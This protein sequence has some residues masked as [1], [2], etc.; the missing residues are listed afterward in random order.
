M[1]ISRSTIEMIRR[2]KTKKD[3]TLRKLRKPPVWLFPHGAERLYIAYL[4]Q[5]TFAMRESITTILM[6]KIKRMLAEATQD[7]PDPEE[8]RYDSLRLDDFIDDL[9][10]T[11]REVE[12]SLIP[13]EQLA[14]EHAR[15]ISLDVAK[16]NS[17]QLLKT[18]KSVLGIDIF[19]NQ[20]WLP[21]QLA[22]FANQ[23]SQLIRNLTENEMNRV[24]GIVQRGFQ[25]GSRYSS[26]AEDIQQ[27]FGITRRHARLIARDQTGKLNASLTKLQQQEVGITQYRWNTV[28]DE[29]VR[30][31]HRAMEGRICR[32]DDPTV[33]LNESTGKWESRKNIG[34]TL[35]H[36]GVDVQCRCNSIAIVEGIFDGKI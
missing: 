33:Y 5:Y 3:G 10:E 22:L 28:H 27:S 2:R 15:E 16:H 21:E 8:S 14:N 26:I 32:W 13:A 25:E 11:M 17:L 7:Y 18:T 19:L 31:D 30:K 36:V 6:P 1:A 9:N 4:W 24:S 20:P 12:V 35:V 23:N 29:R 34:G